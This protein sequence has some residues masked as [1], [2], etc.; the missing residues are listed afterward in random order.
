MP[1]TGPIRVLT[2]DS[3]KGRIPNPLAWGVGRTMYLVLLG[4]V[5]SDCLEEAIFGMREA[6]NVQIEVNLRVGK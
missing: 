5:F 2:K 4:A 1:Q 3:E 6:A